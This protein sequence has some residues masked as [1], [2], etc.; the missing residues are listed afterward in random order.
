LVLHHEVKEVV[1]LGAHLPK[2][3][4]TSGSQR[5]SEVKA[6]RF[7]L[8]ILGYEAGKDAIEVG[9]RQVV[10]Q[11]GVERVLVEDEIEEALSIENR[12]EGV[13]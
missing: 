6:H 11:E 2:V 1:D 5:G 12:E 7:V 10:L 3:E 9:G 13:S 8:S 4:E